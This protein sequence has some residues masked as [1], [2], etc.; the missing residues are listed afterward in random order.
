MLADESPHTHGRPIHWAWFYDTFVWLTSLGQER[1]LRRMTL[2]LAQ[3]RPGEKV[4][5]VGCGTGSLTIGAEER[6][7]PTGEAHGIDAAVEMIGAARAK[8]EKAVA[9]VDFRVGLAECLPFPDDAV[10]VV[11]S[12]LMVHHLPGVDLKRQSFAEMHRV[13]K[14]GGR[15]LIVDIG[16]PTNPLLRAALSATLGRHIGFAGPHDHL[17]LLAEAGFTSFEQGA[18]WG[19][20]VS[21][22]RALAVKGRYAIEG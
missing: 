12:S 9:S 8:A 18:F 19:G 2:D 4:L 22:V 21:W 3:L 16:I 11:L 5:D 20:L 14:P 7:G 13:L 10:D 15:L 1:F 17:P 6:V